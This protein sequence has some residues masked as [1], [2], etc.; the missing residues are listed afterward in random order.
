MRLVWWVMLI[1]STAQVMDYNANN[2]VFQVRLTATDRS[3]MKDVQDALYQR[4]A[5]HI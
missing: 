3:M 4:C 1:L 5:K 2:D